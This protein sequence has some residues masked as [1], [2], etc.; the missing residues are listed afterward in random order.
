MASVLASLLTALLGGEVATAFHRTRRNAI[1][2][3]LALTLIVP[4]YLLLIAA[5]TIALASELGLAA[6]SLVV[7]GILALSGLIVLVAMQAR[8]RRERRMR[9]LDTN[10]EALRAGALAMAVPMLPALFKNRTALLLALAAGSAAFIAT[11]SA[12]GKRR[13]RPYE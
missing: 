12:Q 7:A 1:A 6:A 3:V 8:N 5:V 11:A 10:A 2:V 13:K 4:A 9:S